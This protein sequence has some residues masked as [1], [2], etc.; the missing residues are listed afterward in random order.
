MKIN[1][2]MTITFADVA[3]RQL[4]GRIVAWNEE[5]NTSVGRTMFAKDSIKIDK[6]VKLLLEHDRTR[7][8]GW[9][10]A[11]SAGAVAGALI[12]PTTYLSPNSLDLLLISG[13]VAAVIGGL[14]SLIGAVVGGL[15]LGIGFAFI[16]QYIG[17]SVTF[18]AA[19]IILVIVLFVKPR[20][21]FGS[22]LGRR[23]A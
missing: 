11:G 14:E 23:D 22:K 10:F 5:G 2:P 3:K 9:A 17:T 1:V 13:F 15:L 7:T 8:I 16:L 19:F 21:L 12:T 6:N 20:G 18:S 4:T